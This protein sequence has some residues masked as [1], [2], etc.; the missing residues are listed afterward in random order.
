[1]LLCLISCHNHT[2]KGSNLRLL[3]CTNDVKELIHTAAKI[4]YR[5]LAITDHE[6][7]S[8]HVEAIKKT[9]DLKKKGDI[10]EDFKLILGNEIYL[11]DDLESVRDNYKSGETKFPH[12]LL[13]S[14]DKKGHEQLRYL[15]SKAWEN[16]FYTG[17]MERTPTIKEELAKVVKNEPNHLI[18]STACL[19]SESSIHLMALKEAE[20]NNNAELTQYHKKKVMEFIE[21]NID[22][23]GKENFYI[24]LQPALSEEQIYV[25]QKLIPI[26]D[27]YGLKRIIST[28]THYLR[29]EDRVVHKAFLNAKDG[30]R[31]VDSFYEACY[32]Q[33]QEE[34]YERM[35]YLDREII[36]DAIQ[37]TLL[38]GEM[39]E[40]YTIEHDPIIPKIDLPEFELRHMFEPAYDKYAYISKMAY[41]D[42]EQDRYMVKLLE[43]GFEEYI[44]FNVLT[45]EKFHQILARINVELE[46]LWEISENINQAMTSYYITVREIINIIWDDECGGNSLVGSGRGSAAGF[47]INYLLGITQVNPLEYG[48]ELPHWRHLHKS[49][50]DIPDIDIDTEGSKRP[51]IIKAL[52]NHFGSN[53][54]LQVCTFGTEKSKSALQTACRGLEIDN[55]IA[56]YISGMIPFER[57]QNWSLSDCFYGNEEEGRKPIKEFIREVEKYPHLKETA[58][59]IEGLVNK[60]SIH[61]GGVIIFNEDYYKSNAMMRAP[62]GD[63]VTQFNLGDSE[64]VGNVKFD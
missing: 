24:E 33:T 57:G 1:V 44:P 11:V 52:R 20:E 34:I 3:D 8:A 53:R 54:V 37:N 27:Y 2:A 14:K 30:E 18:A 61:A 5:G 43:D 42:N 21:W 25:N 35:S 31:E 41:S 45:Q 29:P 63:P 56:L 39:V 62:S 22:V 32:L 58:L 15:S 46:E 10:P 23:F 40:D 55:D 47:L 51:Q 36:D 28:D 38:I 64:A 59:K 4:G 50:P 13:I 16:S 48:I 49:R 26:A 12:F 6:S 7:V 60:R 17:T 9:R 19:G